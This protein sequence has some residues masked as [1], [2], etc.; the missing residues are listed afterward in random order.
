MILSHM[1][2]SITIEEKQAWEY[3]AEEDKQRDD[4]EMKTYIP[5]HGYDNQGN[6]LI[7]Y[8]NL[9]PSSL[10]KK[11][12]DPNA[13]KR[14]NTAYVLFTNEYRPKIME[15]NPGIK[16]IDL[17]MTLGEKWR[18]LS[19]EERRKFEDLAQE[20]KVRHAKEMEDYK[21]KK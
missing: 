17:G 8:G 5:P 10:R 18:E 2:K 9:S 3:K 11:Y 16:F 15:D 7:T 13:P 4:E 20:D 19:R 21:K 14:A 1:Y 12:K 6:L